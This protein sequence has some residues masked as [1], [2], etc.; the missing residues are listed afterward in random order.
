[1]ILENDYVV[2]V[3]NIKYYLN[4]DHRGFFACFYSEG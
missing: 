3:G 2:S 1:M 4:I